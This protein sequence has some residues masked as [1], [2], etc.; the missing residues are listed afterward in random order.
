VRAFLAERDAAGLADVVH[1]VAAVDDATDAMAGFDLFALTAREDAYPLACLEAA[2]LGVPL[3]CFDA[4][5]MGE[6]VEGDAGVVVAYP[7]VGAL[8]GAVLDLLDRP[9]ARAAAGRTGAD[10]VRQ[11]HVPDVAAPRLHASLARWEAR[12]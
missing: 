9:E 12:R 7:D 6:F 2:S 4:G 3:V 8:A 5:G 11:R 10:R 1:H